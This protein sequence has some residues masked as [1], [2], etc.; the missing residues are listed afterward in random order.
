MDK[1]DDN[2]DEWLLDG[3]SAWFAIALAAIFIVAMVAWGF[4]EFRANHLIEAAIAVAPVDEARKPLREEL[5]L[6]AQRTMATAAIVAV[7]L[8]AASMI[9]VAATVYFTR[10]ASVQARLS[11]AISQEALNE[12]MASSRRELRPYLVASTSSPTVRTV[13]SITE[14]SSLRIEISIKNYGQTPCYI[15]EVRSYIDYGNLHQEGN[16]VRTRRIGKVVVSQ[17]T[18][19]ETLTLFSAK[20]ACDMRESKSSAT[21]YLQIYCTDIFEDDRKETLLFR[22]DSVLPVVRGEIL[23]DSVAIRLTPNRSQNPLRSSFGTLDGSI[24]YNPFQENV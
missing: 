15:K 10:D 5:D 19:D 17:E 14:K 11:L 23:G 20:R 6:A 13:A 8:S 2:P 9:F 4:G 16:R 24:K 22:I 21:L 3:P 1:R 18:A 7:V 12:A